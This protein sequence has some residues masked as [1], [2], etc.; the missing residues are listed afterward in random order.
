[1]STEEK[2]DGF[3]NI[4]NDNLM[5]DGGDEDMLPVET[6]T[7][8]SF[9]ESPAGFTKCVLASGSPT[10]MSSLLSRRV[11]QCNTNSNALNLLNDENGASPMLGTSVP[12]PSGTNANHSQGT[13][14]NGDIYS[15][16]RRC[17][18]MID[19]RLSPPFKRGDINSFNPPDD[20]TSPISRSN[21]GGQSC[22]FKRPLAFRKPDK[23]GTDLCH[24]VSSKTEDQY[25]EICIDEFSLPPCSSHQNQ[26]QNLR[27]DGHSKRRRWDVSKSRP[28]LLKSQSMSEIGEESPGNNDCSGGF[29]LLCRGQKG[30]GRVGSRLNRSKSVMDPAAAAQ[31]MEACSLAEFDPNRTGDTRR[32]LSLPVTEGHT[33]NQDLKNIDCHTMANVLK[34]ELSDKVARYE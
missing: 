20:F 26:E 28:P 13:G 6:F 7:S 25:Q 18:S 3:E 16:F 23:C 9:S 15:S 21:S 4:L 29:A 32:Q 5:L 8:N 27:N 17:T 33:K 34:G 10:I 24:Q 30:S 11:V 19:Q 14:R 2:E 12:T 1:M 22:G 31:I